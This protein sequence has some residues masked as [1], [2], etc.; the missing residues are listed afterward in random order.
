MQL[1]NDVAIPGPEGL[2]TGAF[3]GLLQEWYDLFKIFPLHVVVGPGHRKFFINTRRD[4]IIGFQP[5]EL[6]IRRGP[7]FT[8]DI[9]LGQ[10]K[11]RFIIRCRTEK[12]IGLV[13]F[14]FSLGL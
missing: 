13:A 7:V 14:G 6:I 8:F 11:Y 5:A 3:N 4:H 2:I 1:G 10:P 12:E 9:G